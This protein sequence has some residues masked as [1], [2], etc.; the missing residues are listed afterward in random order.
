MTKPIAHVS[1]QGTHV[2]LEPLD[3]L[4]HAVDLSRAIDK[5]MQRYMY[6]WWATPGDEDAMR[7]NIAETLAMPAWFSFAV[8]EQS[9]GRAIGSTSYIDIRAA[10]LSLEI[11]STWIS[12]AHRGTRI[13]PEMKLLMLQHVFEGRC[14]DAPA[15]RVQLKTDLR[16]VH[17]QRAI[18]KLGAVRE[19]VLRKCVVMPDGYL[20]DSVVYSITGDEWPAV[21]VGL[22]A[23]LRG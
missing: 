7:R 15:I 14:F 19:G 1:L 6:T 2:R 17:S 12:S 23:R 13:N 10:H 21:K 5:D 11:G 4:S 3:A 18:E 22:E 9:N 16:N 8:I 20:R